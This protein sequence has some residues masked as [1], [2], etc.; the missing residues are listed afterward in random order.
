MFKTEQNIVK[1][2]KKALK[3]GF[4][5]TGIPFAKGTSVK[6]KIT[7]K[8][9]T[10]ILGIVVAV[11]VSLTL[12]ITNEQQIAQTQSTIFPYIDPQTITRAITTV[13][14]LVVT[15]LNIFF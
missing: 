12:W 2:S 4:F 7:Y 8:E 10:L 9:I 13:E 14:T 11:L 15:F 3:N 5:A 6:R 1:T